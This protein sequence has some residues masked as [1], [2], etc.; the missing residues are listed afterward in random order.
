MGPGAVGWEIPRSA[1]SA[2]ASPGFSIYPV[3]LG[4][5]I[6]CPL[7]PRITALYPLLRRWAALVPSALLAPAALASCKVHYVNLGD[8]RG[9]EGVVVVAV[10]LGRRAQA[11]TQ[12]QPPPPPTPTANHAEQTNPPPIIF[13]YF[14][15]TTT[16]HTS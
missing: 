6:P 2:A 9:G 16:H 5:T 14:P 12:A 3:T 8:W 15:I 11:T 10:E 7:H 13:H 4:G 1:V